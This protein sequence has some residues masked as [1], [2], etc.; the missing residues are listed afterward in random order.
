MNLSFQYHTIQIW[1]SILPR[2]RVAFYRLGL[3]HTNYQE[4][5]DE[6]QT[7]L[8]ALLTKDSEIILSALEHHICTDEYRLLDRI[9][10]KQS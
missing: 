5:T 10:S 2:I 3:V 9:E 1:K 8:E 4:I 6:H 7:L